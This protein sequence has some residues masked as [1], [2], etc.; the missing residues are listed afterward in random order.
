[1]LTPPCII[2]FLQLVRWCMCEFVRG[3][4]RVELVMGLMSRKNKRESARPP[5]VGSRKRHQKKR[6]RTATTNGYT[7]KPRQAEIAPIYCSRSISL[8]VPR[9]LER[10]LT[11]WRPPPWGLWRIVLTSGRE[12]E[13]RI[14]RKGCPFQRWVNTHQ[15]DKTAKGVVVAPK[16]C[17]L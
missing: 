8:V 12:M 5:R 4:W 1:M 2:S 10:S 17:S 7:S 9:H 11:T 6:A 3:E 16:A 15:L 13:A 14:I